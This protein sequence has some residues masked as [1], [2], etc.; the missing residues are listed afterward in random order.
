LVPLVGCTLH[1]V[2]VPA[3]A[4]DFCFIQIFHSGTW[5][6][7]VSFSV[8]TRVFFSG[9]KTAVESSRGFSSV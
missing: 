9:G 5:T 4:R 1:V 3:A 8:A 7:P 2:C 6:H